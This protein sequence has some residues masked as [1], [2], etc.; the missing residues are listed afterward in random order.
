VAKAKVKVPSAAAGRPATTRTNKIVG[1]F[2]AA[3]VVA[4]ALIVVAVVLRN[5]PAPAPV[6]TTPVVDLSGIPQNGRVL[7]SPSAR[8]T[9]IEYADP[10]CPGCRAY[11]EIAFPVLVDDYVRPGKVRTEFRGFPF[12]GDDSV[13]GYRFLLAAAEQNHL[14]DL[15]EAMY[16]HQGSENGGWITDDLI[17][18][19]AS[20]I[21]GLDV[22]ELFAD[23]ERE[24][25]RKAA[26]SAYDE[27][28]AAGIPGTPSLFVKVGDEKPYYIRLRSVDDLRSALD[29][30]LAS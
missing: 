13:K 26:E 10:Q 24:D 27:A 12:I 20:E 3:A 1:A 5:D 30:A 17:R 6:N 4:A 22:D 14:W 2:G 23:A 9:L 25:I 7:G 18:Q 15:M 11:T 28:K 29:E 19:L 8:V 21:P 16:R